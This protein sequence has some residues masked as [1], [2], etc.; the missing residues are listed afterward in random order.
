LTAHPKATVEV[1]GRAVPVVADVL[2]E[3]EAER[4]WARILERSP[5]Y[6]R[7]ARAAM[8]RIP[9]LRLI[10]DSGERSRA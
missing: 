3:A 6:E 9:V 5:E 7:Y 10:P 2:P 8:R 1:G 4:W